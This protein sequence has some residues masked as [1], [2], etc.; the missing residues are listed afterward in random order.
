MMENSVQL[1]VPGGG[2]VPLTKL[3]VVLVEDNPMDAELIVRELRRGHFDVDAV[4]V[5]TPEEFAAALE[6]PPDLVLADYNLP[7]M[8]AIR[9]LQ[10][11]WEHAPDVPLIVVT[12]ELGDEAAAECMKLGACDYVLKDRLARLGPAVEIALQQRRIERERQQALEALA[13]SEQRLK[14]VLEASQNAFWD[15]DLPSGRVERG[16]SVAE[17]LGYPPEEMDRIN[18]DW[19]ELIH[20]EDRP[21]VRQALEEHLAGKRAVYEVEYRLRKRDGDYIWVAEHGRVVSHAEDGTPVRIAGTIRDI[22]ES[23]RVREQLRSSM[24]ELRALARRLET[25]REEERTRIAREVHDIL[26]QELTGLKM[27]V[28]WLAEKLRSASVETDLQPFREKL[29]TMAARLDETM[30]TVRRISTELRPA[31]LDTLGIVAALEWQASDFEKRYSI[32]C[33]FRCAEDEIELDEG[34]ATAVFRIF[35]EALTNVARHA[36]ATE[37]TAELRLEGDTLDLVVRDNGIGIGRT[38]GTSEKSL[39][40]LGM[41]ERALMFGGRVEVYGR[42]GVGT[43]V[44]LVLPIPQGG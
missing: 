26:G 44:R 14:L 10:I 19:E 13:E 39:G 27:D 24:E 9:A 4:R 25:V 29:E 23:K 16:G 40:L 21:A 41:Q 37:V 11:V 8:D 12:G 20:P 31:V 15:M 17:M 3:R 32:P 33:S 42:P 43:T 7:A 6:D 36:K 2:S 5:E 38:R 22:T 18:A 34:R 1:Q 30:K 35:Q 28:R